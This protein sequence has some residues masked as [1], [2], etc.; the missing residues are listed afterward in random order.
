M[1]KLLTCV[2]KMK[3]AI[4]KLKIKNLILTHQ[5]HIILFMSNGE[6]NDTFVRITRCTNAQKNQWCQ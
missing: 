6:V 4:A 1:Q 3:N 5:V 2:H